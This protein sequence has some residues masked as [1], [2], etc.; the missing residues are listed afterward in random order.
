M[1]RLDAHTAEVKNI[2]VSESEQGKGYGKAL[3]KYADQVAK[4][5]EC[6]TLLIGTGNSSIGQ[7]ALYQK[8]G[9]EMLRIEKDFFLR[10]YA[11]P[12]WEN[13]I[14]CKHRVILEKRVGE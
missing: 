10:H 12:I 2:A 14:Q 6:E 11:E 1:M 13:G 3:L 9:F 8:V 7:L 5:W 4:E